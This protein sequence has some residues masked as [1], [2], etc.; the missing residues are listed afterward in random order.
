MG[1]SPFI[2]HPGLLIVAAVFIQGCFTPI[3]VSYSLEDLQE[4]RAPDQVY[5]E[6]SA[7]VFFS[8]Y[9]NPYK[10]KE[11]LWFVSFAEG[12]VELRIHDTMTDTVQMVFHFDP[13]ETP[14]YIITRMPEE[15]RMVKCILYVDGRRKCAKLYP[16]WYPFPM[17]HWKTKYTV[18]RR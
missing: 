15:E 2:P 6:D 8:E 9:H 16:A 12:P 4:N 10:D 7:T 17:S 5:F 11:F 3:G 14:L 13:Q 1:S 18:E